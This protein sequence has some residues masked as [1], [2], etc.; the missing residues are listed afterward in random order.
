MRKVVSAITVLLILNSPLLAGEPARLMNAK[1]VS[2]QREV[3]SHALESAGHTCAG[4]SEHMY[5]GEKAGMDFYSVRCD[6]RS[7]YMISIAAAGEMQSRVMMCD[8]LAALGVRCF[9]KL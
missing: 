5:A 8:V 7:E 3:L 1:S 2:E 4:I 9:T 6:D